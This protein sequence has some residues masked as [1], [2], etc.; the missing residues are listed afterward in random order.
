VGDSLSSPPLSL[1][2]SLQKKAKG[3]ESAAEEG[4]RSGL[5]GNFTSATQKSQGGKMS[6]QVKSGVR[7]R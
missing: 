6:G 4:V 3:M 1:L 2:P 5:L 7:E